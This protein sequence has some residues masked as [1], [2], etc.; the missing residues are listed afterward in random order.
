M[1]WCISCQQPTSS[2]TS[3]IKKGMIKVAILYPN[4]EGKTFD[5]DYYSNK[6]MPM[7]AGLFGDS[8]KLYTIDKGIAGRTPDEPLP[9]VAIGYFYFDKL[10]AYHNSFGPNA[11]TILGDIP[12]YTN[13]QP[14]VQI[15]EVLH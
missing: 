7:V 14:I 15:S 12:N 3:K 5:M 4:T 8:L 1:V 6:H 11:E 10:S 13:I 9:Y 2:D